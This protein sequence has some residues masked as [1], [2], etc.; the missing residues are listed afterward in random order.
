[1]GGSGTGKEEGEKRTSNEYRST[2]M[3]RKKVGVSVLGLCG[4][5]LGAG[6]LSL[7]LPLP[8]SSFLFCLCKIQLYFSHPLPYFQLIFIVFL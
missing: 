5:K 2:G 8:D 3:S 6:S 1:M 7:I 4:Q